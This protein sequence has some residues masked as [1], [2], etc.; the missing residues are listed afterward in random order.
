MATYNYIPLKL[1]GL[2]KAE[3]THAALKDCKCFTAEENAKSCIWAGITLHNSTDW[4][5]S[6][7]AS[8][9]VASGGICGWWV[10]D[11]S[12]ACPCSTQAVMSQAMLPST[13]TKSFLPSVW[14]LWDHIRR[15][16]TSLESSTKRNALTCWVESSRELPRWS[17]GWST[18]EVVQGEAEGTGFV[19]H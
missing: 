13:T 10:V 11:E 3:V 4:Q 19:Q 8:S 16:A 14:Y 1:S 18:S 17:W 5:A 15:A 12:A 6:W 7:L 2:E 9:L